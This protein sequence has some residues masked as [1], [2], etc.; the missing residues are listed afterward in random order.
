MDPSGVET[1]LP[2]ST[3][4]RCYNNR[5]TDLPKNL[6]ANASRG[7]W[8]DEMN[9]GPG[10]ILLA[11]PSQ[12]HSD[13]FL[14]ACLL[15]G[16]VSPDGEPG[17]SAQELILVSGEGPDRAVEQLLQAARCDTIA[18]VVERLAP[19][20]FHVQEIQTNWDDSFLWMLGDE[21][22]KRIV[23]LGC[24][25]PSLAQIGSLAAERTVPVAVAR[26]DGSRLDLFL[27]RRNSYAPGRIPCPQDNQLSLDAPHIGMAAVAAGH[28]ACWLSDLDW[29][30]DFGMDRHV[31]LDSARPA[32]GP[33]MPPG[34]PHTLAAL[35]SG[36]RPALISA[37]GLMSNVALLLASASSEV[38][39]II[40]DDDAFT[41]DQWRYWVIRLMGELAGPKAHQTAKVITVVNPAARIEPSLLRIDRGNVDAI[42]TQG[43][44]DAVITT[45]DNDVC[46]SVVADAVSSRIDERPSA[47]AHAI[48]GA[49][50][51]GAEAYVET[52]ST[53]SAESVLLLSDR[54]AVEQGAH[55]L[56][57]TSCA[58]P[59]VE[60]GV[61]ICNLVCAGLLTVELCRV[62]NG[63]AA[64]GC[65][66]RYSLERNLIRVHGPFARQT[67]TQTKAQG[68]LT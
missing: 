63:Q 67:R 66:L 19:G 21:P 48:G 60:A 32:E 31:S 30:V 22:I 17:E 14:L 7:R 13:T 58:D 38:A 27:G 25:R 52:T 1:E 43:S 59:R 39:G 47:P 65:L 53:A 55:E 33:T 49:R 6:W 23:L 2:E 20:R 42:L 10:S 24:D 16:L 68:V 9:K 26:L 50:H 61:I 41:P 51:F 29:Q 36:T 11:T 4:A 8:R 28:L 46:R 35:P 56:E 5:P 34:R 62:L 40:V 12:Q 57:S 64:T 44:F 18:E 45:P 15:A 37:G 3:T 54:A